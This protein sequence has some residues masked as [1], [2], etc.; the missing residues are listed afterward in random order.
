MNKLLPRRISRISWLLFLLLLS[1]LSPHSAF[2]WKISTDSK[3]G[4]PSSPLTVTGTHFKAGASIKVLFKQRNPDQSWNVRLLCRATISDTGAFSCASKV[5]SG[6]TA[7]DAVIKA[8]YPNSRRFVVT[9]FA[10]TSGSTNAQPIADSGANQTVTVNTTVQLDGTASSDPD[11]N[12]LTYHWSLVSSPPGSAATLSDSSSATPTFLADKPGAYQA[13]LIVN[14]GIVDST[15][16]DTQVTANILPPKV[17]V[18][19]TG[20][21]TNQSTQVRVQAQVAP[22]PPPTPNTVLLFRLDGASAPAGTPLCT[23]EDNGNISNGDDIAGD[24]VYSCFVTFLETSPKQIHLVVSAEIAGQVVNSDPVYLNVTDTLTSEDAATIISAQ[25]AAKAFW[26]NNK[27]AFGD[28]TRAREETVSQIR[29]LSGVSS[30]GISED[31]VTIYIVYNSGVSGGLMLNPEGTRGGPSVPIGVR[32]SRS[33][34]IP[35][36]TA[37]PPA[38]FSYPEEDVLDKLFTRKATSPS[39]IPFALD[40]VPVENTNV[41]VWDAYNSDFA[42]HDEGPQLEKLFSESNCPSFNVTYLKDSAATVDSVRSFTEYGTVILVTHGAVDGSGQV[43]FLTRETTTVGSI[44]SHSIDLLLGRV[45]I[46]GDVFAIRPSFISSLSGSFESSIIYN[47]SCESSANATMANA[48]AAKGAKTYHGFTRVV[49][50]DYAQNVANQLFENLVTSLQNTGDS[51]SSVAPKI[52][53]KAPNATFTQAGDLKTIYSGDLQN[54]NFEKGDLTSWSGSGDARALFRL[55]EVSPT[56]GA[57]LGLISTGLGFTTSSGSIEQN[58]CLPKTATKLKFKW[59]FN[60]EE[61][62]EWCGSIFDDTLEVNI[63]TDNGPT[64]L[65]RTGVNALC[66]SVKRTDLYFDQSGPGC[67]P[68]EGVGFGTGGNDCTIWSTDWRSEDIDISGIAAA[69]D[70]KGVKI[71]FKANDIG[72]SIFD[73]AVTLDDVKIEKAE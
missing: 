54:G 37:K 51:F 11:G 41:L 50:S 45:T 56:E 61:F 67:S 4:A 8:I 55:G 32:A 57:F 6:A 2:A 31:N 17:S 5:P 38:S 69:N 60:S 49:N 44:I 18:E 53:P 40:D 30:A 48:F 35:A 19:P 72:D 46:M 62:I 27:S 73:T 14:D 28:T 33:M 36:H 10:V 26:L 52:D 71:Q 58:F 68:S 22:I 16:S 24:S 25:S 43:I 12:P 9:Q 20:F 21:L 39:I 63:L 70:G 34:P 7:G 15:P 47:G 64:T 13:E 65:L 1:Y 59:N 3:S 29:T 23:L 42:P 66:A